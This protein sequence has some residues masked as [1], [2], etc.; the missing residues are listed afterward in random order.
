M[1]LCFVDF[2]RDATPFCASIC[3]VSEGT[4]GWNNWRTDET[5]IERYTVERYCLNWICLISFSV[6]ITDIHGLV[7]IMNWVNFANYELRKVVLCSPGQT[8]HC[9]YEHSNECVWSSWPVA[10][11][12]TAFALDKWAWYGCFAAWIRELRCLEE[13]LSLFPVV[14]SVWRKDYTQFLAY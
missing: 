10:T 1:V 13:H 14:L 6:E 9:E 12:F 7:L 8:K 2:E 4:H 3:Q 11:H 5:L